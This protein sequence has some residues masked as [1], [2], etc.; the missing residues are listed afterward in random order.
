MIFQTDTCFNL[1]ACKIH[2]WTNS[3]VVLSSAYCGG[4]FFR[5]TFIAEK[6]LDDIGITSATRETVN[7][8]FVKTAVSHKL[9]VKEPNEP[10]ENQ[11]SSCGTVLQQRVGS[12][13]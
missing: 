10:N 12:G 5:G 6:K 8:F 13:V 7:A 11:T 3:G 2:C 9:I 4:S 1:A